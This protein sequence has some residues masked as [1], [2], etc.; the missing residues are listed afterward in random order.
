MGY[1]VS[2]DK[3]GLTHVEDL[4]DHL[5]VLL[6]TGNPTLVTLRLQ[7]ARGRIPFTALG[8]SPLYL[9]DSTTINDK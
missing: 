4:K 5:E 7:E 6:P 3:T 1:W 9:H 8:N 2:R